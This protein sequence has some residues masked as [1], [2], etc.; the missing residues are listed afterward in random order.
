MSDP[1]SRPES[2]TIKSDPKKHGI[3]D[4]DWGWDAIPFIVDGTMLLTAYK[5]FENTVKKIKVEITCS[6]WLWTFNSIDFLL[7][8]TL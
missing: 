2:Y 4:D 1:K 5:L 3:P 8:F 7:C 6:F